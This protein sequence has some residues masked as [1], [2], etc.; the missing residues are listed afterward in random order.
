VLQFCFAIVVNA[1]VLAY[2]KHGVC[3][4]IHRTRKMECFV[5][6]KITFVNLI[7]LSVNVRV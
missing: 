5:S 7:T 6:C 4:F 3:V 2:F 1:D